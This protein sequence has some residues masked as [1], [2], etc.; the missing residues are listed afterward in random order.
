VTYFLRG[1]LIGD[2]LSGLTGLGILLPPVNLSFNSSNFF[3][4]LAFAAENSGNYFE[5]PNGI[6]ISIFLISSSL[7]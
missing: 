4:T 1:S 2:Y 5:P 6:I 7:S 3:K